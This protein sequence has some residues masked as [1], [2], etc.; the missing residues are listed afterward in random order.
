LRDPSLDAGSPVV[1]VQSEEFDITV[2][3]GSA[4]S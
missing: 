3:D 4:R 2:D 1:T